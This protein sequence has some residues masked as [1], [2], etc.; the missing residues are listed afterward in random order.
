V[1]TCQEAMGSQATLCIIDQ[2]RKAIQRGDIEEYKRLAAP[3][4][5]SHDKTN[6]RSK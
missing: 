3:R 5:R 6:G 4:R 2:W 1:V